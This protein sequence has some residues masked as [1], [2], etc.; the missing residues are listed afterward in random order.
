MPK[1]NTTQVLNTPFDPLTAE[2]QRRARLLKKYKKLSS[3]L[4]EERSLY[5]ER[6]NAQQQMLQQT[7]DYLVEIKQE[8]QERNNDIL[9]SVRYARYIQNSILPDLNELRAV[10]P[11]S[12]VFY[13]PKDIVSGDLPWL[14]VYGDTVLIAA[15][16]CTGHGVPGAMISMLGYSLLNEVIAT[17]AGLTPA[18]ILV[19]LNEKV[20]ES[21][22]HA[23]GREDVQDGM[24]I[25]L[26]QY[27]RSTRTLTFAGAKR[28][29]LWVQ[30]H[31]VHEIP[32]SQHSIGV[33]N[34]KPEDFQNHSFSVVASDAV[35]LFSD[36]F[37]DQFG[38]ETGKKY[39]RGRFKDFCKTI[40][41]LPA[42]VQFDKLE[43]E[44]KE[45]KGKQR[46]TDDVLVV[47]L[48]F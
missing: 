44:F 42:D 39:M 47:G 19:E 7:T 43:L 21:F 36:G 11:E 30:G 17:K 4:V 46:Q 20:V 27:N 22:S 37:V 48:K 40:S 41:Q 8:L 2:K 14:K 6:L 23:D 35:Y 31:E 5:E 18:Q 10:V 28:P 25:A 24:D 34:L 33:P 15:M 12:F 3:N 45:W 13:Q 9:A 38:E 1:A 26:L 29:L 16:D 32:G